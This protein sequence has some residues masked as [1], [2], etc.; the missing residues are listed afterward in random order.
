MIKIFLAF[1]EW[2]NFE[3][4][5]IEKIGG[6]EFWNLQKMTKIEFVKRIN[7]IVSPV[8]QN[9]A[10]KNEKEFNS[11]KF[12]RLYDKS[13]WG[14]LLPNYFSESMFDGDEQ[15]LF[16]FELYDEPTLPCQYSIMGNGILYREEKEKCHNLDCHGKY[17]QFKRMEFIKFFKTMSRF[18]DN[19]YMYRD[20]AKSWE[21]E[22]WRKYIGIQLLKRISKRNPAK[23][24][25]FWQ[26]EC[27]E[28]VTFFEL[29]LS[30]EQNDTKS[31]QIKQRLKVLF[32]DY[33][34]NEKGL[35]SETLDDLYNMRNGFI[36]GDSFRRI[37]KYIKKNTPEGQLAKLPQIGFKMLENGRMLAK[38]L[39]V[40]YLY[41]ESQLNQINKSVASEIQDSV[42]DVSKRRNLQKNVLKILKLL[43]YRL[44]DKK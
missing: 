6:F 26:E 22:E 43:P 18:I 1:P 24:I 2:E 9:V 23:N 35:L 37:T 31:F 19:Y 7:K 25:I 41:L 34:K 11:D 4:G 17:K 20:T 33:Y 36:H 38:Q 3:G 27:S 40:S 42:I 13:I 32:D 14:V 28:L 8:N 16:L 12:M 44:N 15:S 29:M 30:T 5:R 10:L 39:F 21:A